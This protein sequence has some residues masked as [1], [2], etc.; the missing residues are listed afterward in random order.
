MKVYD[1]TNR[2]GLTRGIA[3]RYVNVRSMLQTVLVF[4]VATHQGTPYPF[5]TSCSDCGGNNVSCVKGLCLPR[6]VSVTS[7][8]ECDQCQDSRFYGT[9]C[10][11]DCPDTCLNSRC[12]VTNTRVVCKDGCV[13]GKK[14]DNCG[15]DCPIGCLNCFRYNGTCFGQCKYNFYGKNCH[16]CPA[17]CIN[18]CDRQSG[19]CN[20]CRTGWRGDYCGVKCPLCVNC[21]N[22]EGC[23]QLCSDGIYYGVN[24]Q[25]GC[26]LHCDSCSTP[27]QPCKVC[28]AC[29]DVLTPSTGSTSIPNVQKES[30]ETLKLVCAVF[31]TLLFGTFALILYNRCSKLIRLNQ[32]PIWNWRRLFERRSARGRDVDGGGYSGSTVYNK[33]WEIQDED[34]DSATEARTSAMDETGALEDNRGRILQQAPNNDVMARST[35]EKHRKTTEDKTGHC[36]IL[37]RPVG[38]T[39]CSARRAAS[40]DLGKPNKPDETTV[41]R[42]HSD[43]ESEFLFAKY[44][45][46]ENESSLDSVTLFG[47]TCDVTNVHVKYIT[48]AVVET[49]RDSPV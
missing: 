41:Q 24:C 28:Q 49:S 37:L 23:K 8:G 30:N 42:S 27:T 11:N 33:Y 5:G 14:G 26:P 44:R 46:T 2:K 12:Q 45:N 43:S 6:C 7:S 9:Q 29:K 48:A 21:A 32:R 1:M 35:Y 34:I 13:A 17:N 19:T 36:K 10:Q 47:Q 3:K 20:G 22:T 18:G 16:K 25:H 31:G 38:S 40:C 4:I 39:P 15:V